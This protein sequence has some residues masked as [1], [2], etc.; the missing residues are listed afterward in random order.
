MNKTMT[1]NVTK[2]A[3]VPYRILGTN[4]ALEETS[5]LIGDYTTQ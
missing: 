4:V 5:N 2:H 3:D 1:I